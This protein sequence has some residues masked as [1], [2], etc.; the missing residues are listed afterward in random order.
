M[1]GE[2]LFSGKI[3]DSKYLNKLQLV[4]CFTSVPQ[5]Y[6]RGKKIVTELFKIGNLINGL[7]IM[8]TIHEENSNSAFGKQNFFVIYDELD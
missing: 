2:Q 6:L 5:V 7:I 1:S 4:I 3:V 8:D